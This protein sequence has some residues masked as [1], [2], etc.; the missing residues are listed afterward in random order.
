MIGKLRFEINTRAHA[1]PKDIPL[2]K[3][4]KQLKF[5]PTEKPE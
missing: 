1:T 3:A 4:Q 2:L 5:L